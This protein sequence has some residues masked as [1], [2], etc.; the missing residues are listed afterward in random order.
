MLRTSPIIVAV[1]CTSLFAIS[2]ANAA[3]IKVLATAAHID[4]FKD[5]VPQFERASGHK[6]TVAYNASPVTMKNI[7]AGENFD[8]VVAISGPMNEVAKKGFLAADERPVVS[9]VGLGAAVRAGAPKPDISSPDAFKQA[10]LKAK[11]VSIL[12]ESVNGKHF[13]SV[14][15][16]LGI[17]D[18]MKAKIVPAKAPGDVP[19]AVAK[20]DAEIALFISNGLRAPGVDYVG[21]VPTEFQQTLVFTAATSSKSREPEAARAFIKHLMSPAAAAVMKSKGMDVPGS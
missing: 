11:A 4:S 19:G 20:G 8:V 12:P 5:I 9:S 10:L 18:E 6:V 21:P 2:G 13:I 14:F 15:E 3:E 7:E 1:S 16:R 17:G